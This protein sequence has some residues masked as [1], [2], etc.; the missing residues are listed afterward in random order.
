MRL[1]AS[2]LTPQ[3]LPWC[4]A[5]MFGKHHH[6]KGE[7]MCMQANKTT[8]GT[9]WT[10][11]GWDEFFAYCHIAYFN[12]EWVHN[13]RWFATGQAPADY[14]TSR[15]GNATVAWIS[16]WSKA[17]ATEKKPFFAY[18]APHA[19]CVSSPDCGRC[20]HCSF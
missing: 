12:C 10:P 3:L 5:G 19:P 1:A 9:L 2:N 17:P 20:G 4:L 14:A 11:P 15:I 13:G 18:L 7:R 8:D 6:M 16:K